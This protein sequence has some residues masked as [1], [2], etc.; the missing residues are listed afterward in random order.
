[1]VPA[2]DLRQALGGGSRHPFLVGDGGDCLHAL[3][4]ANGVPHQSLGFQ[5]QVRNGLQGQA[6]KARVMLLRGRISNTTRHAHETRFQR[7]LVFAAVFL[8]LKPQAGMGCTFGAQDGWRFWRG[9]LKPQARM[10]CTF[11]AQDAGA[12]GE[13][14]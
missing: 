12:F 13:A 6:L 11:G 8:G 14:G 5:P 4:N 7:S 1:M 2:P 10:G 3:L 9:G